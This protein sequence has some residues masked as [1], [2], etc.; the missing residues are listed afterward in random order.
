MS[1]PSAGSITGRGR[2]VV[3]LAACVF[4]LACIASVGAGGRTETIT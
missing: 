2:G 1:M 3:G 4:A